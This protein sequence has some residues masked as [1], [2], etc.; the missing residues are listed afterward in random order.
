M[1]SQFLVTLNEDGS[2]DKVE[3]VAG[4]VGHLLSQHAYTLGG[5]RA[6]M[7]REDNAENEN[8]EYHNV[9]LVE[10]WN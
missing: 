4:G 7:L 8:A 10:F 9:Q 3:E 6:W 5:E 1:K 2:V